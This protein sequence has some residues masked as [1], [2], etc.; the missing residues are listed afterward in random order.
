MVTLDDG[1]YVEIVKVFGVSGNT[2]TGCVRGQE[3][4]TA[5]SFVATTKVENRLTASS[6][7]QLARLSD[8]LADYVS[9]E[10]LPSPASADGNSILCASLDPSGSPII[11]MISGTKWRL[12]N[13]PDLIKVGVAGS[14]GSLSG[15]NLTSASNYLIDTISKTYVIQFT[16][17][18]NIGRCRFI[19]TVSSGSIGWATNLPSVPGISDTFEIYRAAYASFMP[20]GAGGDKIFFENSTNVYTNYTV[21]V[22]KNASS[23]GPISI[24]SGVTVTIPSGSSWSIV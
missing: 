20:T 19:T 12:L 3:G 9:I 21:P 16:S 7:Q 6:I 4:T 23:A 24:A 10:D 8:R 13:Y 2:L 14:G 5:R 17:G 18:A 22:G 1:V 15:I 11:G